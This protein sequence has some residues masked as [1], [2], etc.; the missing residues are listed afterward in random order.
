MEKIAY[1][2]VHGHVH[3]FDKDNSVLCGY[4]T[5]DGAQIWRPDTGL[6][7]LI[8]RNGEWSVCQEEWYS[9]RWKGGESC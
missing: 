5:A 7:F 1:K 4:A 6:H 2:D 3:L 8:C 9:A